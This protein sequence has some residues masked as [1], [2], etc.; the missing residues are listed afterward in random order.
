MFFLKSG[1]HVFTDCL[2]EEILDYIDLTLVNYVNECSGMTG[3]ADFLGYSR[4]GRTMD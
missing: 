3:K 2:R 4:L 1:R